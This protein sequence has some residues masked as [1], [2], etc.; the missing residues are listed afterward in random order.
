[1]VDTR[2]RE[3]RLRKGTP[4]YVQYRKECAEELQAWRHLHLES[5]M[6]NS[7]CATASPGRKTCAYHREYY[8]NAKR[9]QRVDK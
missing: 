5:G 6:C 3:V 4:E 8:R 7:C 2:V 9:R 1:M